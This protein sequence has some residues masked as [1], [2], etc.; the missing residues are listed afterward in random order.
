MLISVC[1]IHKGIIQIFY[2]RVMS[3]DP[4]WWIDQTARLAQLVERRTSGTGVV[5]SNLTLGASFLPS[6]L[7]P[8]PIKFFFLTRRRLETQALGSTPF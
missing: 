7:H 3:S 6:L 8:F 4:V 2:I 5:S 1:V